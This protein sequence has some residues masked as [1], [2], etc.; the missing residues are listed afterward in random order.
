MNSSHAYRVRDRVD[1]DGNEGEVTARLA[2]GRPGSDDY[3]VLWDNG[4]VSVAWGSDL[5]PVEGNS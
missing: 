1:Y 2:S 3:V 5:T 4:T